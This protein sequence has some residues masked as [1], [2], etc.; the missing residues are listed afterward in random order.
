MGRLLSWDGQLLVG[1]LP[2]VLI[3]A[4]LN[5]MMSQLFN[6]FPSTPKVLLCASNCVIDSTVVVTA[7]PSFTMY[8]WALYHAITLNKNPAVQFSQRLA[9]KPV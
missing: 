3:S 4:L 2:P 5:S 6:F 9:N 7:A 8:S 1:D